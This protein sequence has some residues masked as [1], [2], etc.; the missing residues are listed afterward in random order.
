MHSVAFPGHFTANWQKPQLSRFRLTWSSEVTQALWMDCR[1]GNPGA[2]FIQPGPHRL[3]QKGREAPSDL[4]AFALSFEMSNQKVYSHLAKLSYNSRACF[5]YKPVKQL[6]HTSS[7]LH[8]KVTNHPTVI[9]NNYC[10]LLRVYWQFL[11]LRNLEWAFWVSSQ[12]NIKQIVHCRS[13]GQYCFFLFQ[14]FKF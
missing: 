4:R 7:H 11:S 3:L 8:R 12:R 2:D 10:Y 1:T 13:W 5:K 9:A 14:C 6:I